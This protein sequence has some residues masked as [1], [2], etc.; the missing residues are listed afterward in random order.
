MSF[1]DLYVDDN[2]DG[3]YDDD[4]DYGGNYGDDNNNVW[5]FAPRRKDGFS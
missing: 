3:N 1:L 4:Y 2:Y 5:L